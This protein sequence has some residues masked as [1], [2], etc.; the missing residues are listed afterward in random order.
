M[1]KDFQIKVLSFVII[2][3]CC[4]FISSP[5]SA[6]ERIDA[7]DESNIKAFIENTTDITTGNSQNLSAKD[8]HA[9]LD[10]HLEDKARFKSVMK[11]NIP[12]MPPQE[13]VLSL[14]KDGYMDSVTEGAK[15]VEGYETLIE[16]TEIKVAS[17]GKKAFVKTANTEYA[18][19][20]IP[21]ETGGTEEVPIEGVSECTQILSLNSGVIQMFS[22]NCVTE[23]NFLEY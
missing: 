13:A 2:A 22:A 10:K 16:I 6:G 20:A 14:D 12:G 7:L 15:S 18:N 5:S 11:Y 8:L 9:Y 17:N 3:F 21:T 19:M 4:A 1:R 23:V